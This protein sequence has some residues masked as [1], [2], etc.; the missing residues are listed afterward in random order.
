[1]A[2]INASDGPIYTPKGRA[3]R[4]R[5]L[6]SAAE[7]L[8]TEGISGFNLDKVRRAGSVSGSQLTHYFADRQALMRAVVERQI[9]VVLDFH[10]QPSLAGLHTFDDFE[11]WAVLNLTYLRQI[12]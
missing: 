4:E 10:R 3:T 5:I 6:L 8:L 11:H 12:G 2:S 9:E 7:V 1:M